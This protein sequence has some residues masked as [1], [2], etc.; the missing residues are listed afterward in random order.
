MK[1]MRSVKINQGV[2]NMKKTLIVVALATAFVLAFSAAALA[3]GPFFSSNATAPNVWNANYAGYLRW[4]YGSTLT[5]AGL[6]PHGDY[7]TSTNKCAVC[8]SVHRAASD[9]TVLTAINDRTLSGYSGSNSGYTRGCGFCHGHT[10]TFSVKQ[11]GM[12]TD[13]TISPHS[14][15]NRCHIESPHGA[16]ASTFAVLKAIMINEDPDAKIEYDL[17]NN[18]NGLTA[19]M[20]DG[21]NASLSA[22]GKTL[23]TGYLCNTC[24]SNAQGGKHLAFAVN[25]PNAAPAIGGEGNPITAGDATGH[26]VTATVT[27]NW[28]QTPG[29]YNAFF[30]GGGAVGAQSQIA[31]AP[32]NSCQT[33]HDAK[34]A[35]GSY[36]FPH[37]YVD[38][39]GAYQTKTTAGAS[40]VWLTTADSPGAAHTVL[41]TTAGGTSSA[42]INSTNN[43]LT[44]DGLC[45]KCHV[46]DGGTAGVGI[47]Y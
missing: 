41:G 34:K 20:F 17:T 32:A 13:G 29:Q 21:T 11:V 46:A 28:N 7:A 38:G 1:E 27:T 33:C 12:G 37:G 18:I 31:W 30:T 43:K 15:C 2:G 26:R 36:A 19:D 14:N 24:H 47:T 6:S 5:S 40:L 22:T 10:P 9:G 45:I 44:E 42:N 8:H 25:T 23:G 35:D 3:V 16:G 39:A 4:S